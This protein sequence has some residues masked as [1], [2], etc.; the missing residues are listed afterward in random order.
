MGDNQ[1]RMK[2]VAA[3]GALMRRL[4]AGDDAAARD[5]VDRFAR[6]LAR[7][8]AG[9]LNDAAEGEDVAHEAIMRLWRG[10][11]DW[12]PEGAIGG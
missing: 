1:E 5:L 11:K 6:P 3:D 9:I 2:A 12:R 7:F 8:A 10:A 4:A